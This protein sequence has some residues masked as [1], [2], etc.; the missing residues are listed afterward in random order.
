MGLRGFS[1]SVALFV[2]FSQLSFA[3]TSDWAIVKALSPGQK[4]KVMTT[5]GNSHVGAVQSVADDA[6]R[7]G[8]DQSIQKQDVRRVQLR[9]PGHHGRNA[10]I[11]LGVG[12]VVGVASG[13]ATGCSPNDKNSFC[14]VTKGEAIAILT[15]FF[16]GV[17]GGIGA[18]L[19][20]HGEWR[21]IYNSK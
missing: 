5:D 8:K 21:D 1:L 6:I 19:P 4:V 10:L 15:P 12:A 20:S 3:Q 9:S 2:L 13:A 18:L 7:I 11:G 16:A 14:F 17:G